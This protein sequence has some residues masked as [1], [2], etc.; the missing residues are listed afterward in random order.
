MAD[1][2]AVVM[3]VFGT[4]V[5]IVGLVSY[6]RYKTRQL[7][8]GA[9]KDKKE[10]EELIKAETGDAV[11]DPATQAKVTQ[12]VADVNQVQSDI[13]SRNPASQNNKAS[14]YPG[15]DVLTQKKR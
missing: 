13:A 4:P 10:L 8:A 11:P 5:A 7:L 15:L 3:I 6:F 14:E 9:P 2:P 1:G 12:A